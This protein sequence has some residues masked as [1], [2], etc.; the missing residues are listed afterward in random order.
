M[1]CSE[2]SWYV[3]AGH[4]EHLRSFEV[5]VSALMSWPALQVMWALHVVARCD[6][7]SWYVSDGHLEHVRAATSESLL[8]SSPAPHVG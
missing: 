4:D 7:L 5:A 3:L 8:I 2:L 1:R 6:V